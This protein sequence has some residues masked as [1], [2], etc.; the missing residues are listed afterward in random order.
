MIALEAFLLKA[1]MLS[2]LLD[3]QNLIQTFLFRLK[4][5]VKNNDFELC[6]SNMAF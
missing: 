3:N 6:S 1:I 2:L 5:S 4:L